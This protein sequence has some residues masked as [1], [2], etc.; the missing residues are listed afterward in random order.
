MIVAP[1]FKSEA[2]TALVVNQLQNKVKVVA[3]K[4]PRESVD[5]QS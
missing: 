5:E 1:D 2:L 4:I 3:V